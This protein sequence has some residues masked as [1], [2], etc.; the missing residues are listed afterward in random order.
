M[1]RMALLKLSSVNETGLRL[2]IRFWWRSVNA[3]K[4]QLQTLSVI[5]DLFVTYYIPAGFFLVIKELEMLMASII[6]ILFGTAAQK[7][8][9]AFSTS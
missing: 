4:K 7:S 9:Q 1:K 5:I 8:A 2:Y 6:D 3:H